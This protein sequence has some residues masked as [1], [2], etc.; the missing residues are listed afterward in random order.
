VR[1]L[2]KEDEYRPTALAYFKV[3]SM[4]LPKAARLSTGLEGGKFGAV[5]KADST[6]VLQLGVKQTR[7]PSESQYRVSSY[8]SIASPPSG[9]TTPLL[10]SLVEYMAGAMSS[11]ISHLDLILS[12]LLQGAHNSGKKTLIGQAAAQ[13]GLNVVEVDCFGLVGDSE[14]RTEANLKAKVERAI[15][16]APC[17]LLLSNAD[18]LARK[19]QAVETGQDSRLVAAVQNCVEEL[20]EA[21]ATSGWPVILAATTSDVDKIPPALLA[22]FKTQFT[23]EAPAQLERFHLLQ[24]I[25]AEDVLSPDVDLD[26]IATQTAALVTGDLVALVQKARLVAQQRALANQCAMPSSCVVE[27]NE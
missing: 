13:T 19:S 4:S 16:C 3:A 6:Q 21:W 12:F 20:R 25:L 15:E 22:S 24:Q 14:V 8:F 5:L 17:I 18:A 11:G 7:L 9:R 1:R 26:S 27:A 23:L 10:A 2:P